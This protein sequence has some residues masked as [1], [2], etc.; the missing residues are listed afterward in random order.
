MQVCTK[1]R[2]QERDSPT[3][4]STVTD[5]QGDGKRGKQHKG[6]PSTSAKQKKLEE[7][8]FKRA[9]NGRGLNSS[10]CG[11]FSRL[12]KHIKSVETALKHPKA[13]KVCNP[14]PNPK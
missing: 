14:N 12:E 3:A 10:L 11:N 6:R 4:S 8:E 1:Q 13:C 2:F 9:K 7:K 5:E